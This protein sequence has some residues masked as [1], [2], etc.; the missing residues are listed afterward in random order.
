MK[1]KLLSLALVLAMALTML[2]TAALAFPADTTGLE[3]SN[4]KDGSLPLAN[5]HDAAGVIKDEDLYNHAEGASKVV[6]DE[7]GSGGVDY[8]ITVTV[9]SLRKHTNADGTKSKK[10][11]WV[12]FKLIAG[13][14]AY[15][16]YGYGTSVEKI[17]SK[18]SEAAINDGDGT[19]YVP[20]YI[21]AGDSEEVANKKFLRVVWY[22]GDPAGGTAS[23]QSNT[24]YEIEVNLTKAPGSITAATIKWPDSTTLIPGDPYVPTVA[25]ATVD[26][27]TDADA[28]DALEVIKL[29]WSGT[30]GTPNPTP[31]TGFTAPTAPGTYE[32]TATVAVNDEYE[33]D[34]QLFNL[35]EE[36]VVSDLDIR[37]TSTITVS[38]ETASVSRDIKQ[39]V[40]DNDPTTILEALET[41]G[42]T[43][44]TTFAAA[45]Q[46]KFVGNGFTYAQG[47]LDVTIEAEL[48]AAGG[49]SV[50]SGY[51][52][53]VMALNDLTTEPLN[54]GSAS[55]ATV[56]VYPGS[57]RY[58]GIKFQLGSS[59]NVLY[60]VI[61]RSMSAPE[62]TSVVPTYNASAKTVTVTWDMK[63]DGKALETTT[64]TF[65][66]HLHNEKLAETGYVDAEDS[67]IYVFY[68]TLG[69][70][71]SGNAGTAAQAETSQIPTVSCKA[72]SLGGGSYT[73]TLPLTSALAN[74]SYTT[75]VNFD[76]SFRRGSF[77][78]GGATA[79]GAATPSTPS[80]PSA[81]TVTDASSA[82]AA[83]KQVQK[84][85]SS[86][87]ASS[88]QTALSSGV[89]T[90]PSSASKPTAAEV[91]AA[92][93]VL[94]QMT[95]LDQAIRDKANIDVK[96]VMESGASNAINANDV[97]IDYAALN[98]KEGTKDATINFRF[99]AP[100]ATHAL[101]RTYNS[102]YAVAYNITL[103]DKYVVNS[104]N[105][106]VPLVIT[107][108]VP[109]GITPA[110]AVVLHY[111]GGSATPTEIYPS[112][113]G[114]KISF[115]VTGF[116]DFVITEDVTVTGNSRGGTGS[117]TSA[118]SGASTGAGGGGVIVAAPS[119]STG[120][121]SAPSAPS[122]I[123]T[124][125]PYGHTFASPIQW[126]R[127]NGIL[128]G[129]S[130]GSFKPDNY[131]TRQALWMVLGR[132]AGANPADMAAA[133]A[134]SVN[135]GISDGTNPTGTLSRQQLITMLYRVEAASGTPTGSADLS[136]FGDS[137][138]VA[139]YAKEA[140]AWGVANGII[141]GNNGNL[142]PEGPAT[143][144][145]F[146][147]FL[148]RYAN[149]P[150]TSGGDVG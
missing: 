116:S 73:A 48:K 134:W 110:N 29:T 50:P 38:N 64:G 145:H 49:G 80:V 22:D 28:K 94:E 1:K 46:N 135:S 115:V 35:E 33:D 34:Y 113:S 18:D 92:R 104:T 130:D 71:S 90:A 70:S 131:T 75:T 119:T 37:N 82:S 126:A 17:T 124:D 96:V 147:A 108:P 67:M 120:A 105:L 16:E 53:S 123:F 83:A 39:G 62:I 102:A 66:I 51:T 148:Y 58:I 132:L 149:L 9:D 146:A 109:S 118:R 91:Q 114:N 47:G 57:T 3:P 142:N 23:P 59:D 133:R 13:S 10:G 31:R 138:L 54:W 56:R 76:G 128:G 86:S 14:N 97:S 79:G 61:G 42:V 60:Y 100:E 117:S 136:A 87:L 143:R 12:G 137:N 77:A 112:V 106:Y 85:G 24:V 101:P 81:S 150:A 55:R 98:L 121:P 15:A 111:H 141:T 52:V 127:D 41:A 69:S 32:V 2:P 107:M 74:G 139:S 8:K 72:E 26:G 20:F 88:L 99:A 103:E 25:T 40:A 93:K 78:V 19:R 5:L 84:V 89:T 27:T 44:E 43:G 63:A 144:A 95:A 68:A 11:Y 129:Y 36:E 30:N 4:H 140:L 45:V 122:G 7:V 21:N 65:E 6:V 125:V